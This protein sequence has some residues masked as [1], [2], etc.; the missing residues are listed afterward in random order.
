MI[1]RL[2]TASTVT[3]YSRTTAM[4]VRFFYVLSFIIDVD[5]QDDSGGGTGTDT[6]TGTGY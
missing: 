6:D 3:V 4:L 2:T 5:D 1:G